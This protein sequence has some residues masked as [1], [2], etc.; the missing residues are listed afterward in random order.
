[1][2]LLDYRRT[3]T[4][5]RAVAALVRPGDTV[6]D[7]GSGTGI[8]ALFAAAAGAGRVIAVEAD[9]RLAGWIR[10]TVQ[11]NGFGGRISVLAGDARMMDLPVAD[12]LVAE[13]VETALI[14]ETLIPVLNELRG[15]GVIGA[16]TRVLPCQY[17][18]GLQLVQVDQQMYGFTIRT[19]RHEWPFYALPGEWCPVSVRHRSGV[20]A[21]WQSRLDAGPVAQRVDRRLTVPVSEPGEVNGVRISGQA[22]LTEDLWLGACN[23]LNG[24]KIIPLPARQVTGPV[25]LAVRYRMGAGLAELDVGWVDQPDRGA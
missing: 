2:C 24:D 18:T 4:L 14:E 7:V 5:R 1:M 8:L 13:L 11:A 6:V 19:M 10:E 9:T 17:R 21:V 12:V 22:G 25:E 15:R 3:S 16:N 23:T 20:V